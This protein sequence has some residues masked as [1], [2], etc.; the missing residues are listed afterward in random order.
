MG[1]ENA[2]TSRN[3]GKVH[4]QRGVLLLAAVLVGYLVNLGCGQV[5]KPVT[6]AGAEARPTNIQR[7]QGAWYWLEK[8]AKAGTHLVRTEASGRKVLVTAEAL[9]TYSWEEGKLIW[10]AREGK[11]WTISLAG[12]DGSNPHP[13]WSGEEEPIGLNLSGGK[14]TWLHRL[15]AVAENL[16]FPPLNST[17][18]VLTLSLEGGK[19]NSIAHLSESEDGV[20]LGFQGDSLYVATYRHDPPGSFCLYR[21]PAG[22]VPVRIAGEIGIAPAILTKDGGLYWLA[23]SQE[24]ARPGGACVRHLDKAG[25]P[26]TLSDW[27]P[28]SGQLYETTHGVVLGDREGDAAVWAIGKQDEFPKPFPRPVG[29]YGWGAGEGEMLLIRPTTSPVV[30]D[31][32]EVSLP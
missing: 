12:A 26:E 18:E 19:P 29:Y 13:L 1:M 24:V 4:W 16:P 31:I 11:Q 2:I 21:I 25:H 23:K 15:P 3:D 30:I 32:A 10:L 22:G 9:S 14:L 20:V 7:H 8:T 6:L 17:L 28:D 27:L 5:Q